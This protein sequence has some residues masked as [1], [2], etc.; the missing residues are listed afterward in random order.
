MNI[1]FRQTR[2]LAPSLSKAIYLP[3]HPSYHTCGK[4]KFRL[5]TAANN[6]SF[7]AEG[8][9]GIAPKE[10]SQIPNLKLNDGHEIPLV[11][12]IPLVSSISLIWLIQ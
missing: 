1:G 4:L 12:F 7:G 9:L 11:G 3:F 2:I 5:P 10:M 6:N 8:N